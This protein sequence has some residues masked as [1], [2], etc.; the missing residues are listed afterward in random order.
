M[1]GANPVVSLST[2]EIKGETM[3][4]IQLLPAAGAAGVSLSWR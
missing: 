3:R 1:G 4:R 2:T